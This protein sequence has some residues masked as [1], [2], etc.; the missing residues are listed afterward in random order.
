MRNALTLR[1]IA[2]SQVLF[3]LVGGVLLVFRETIEGM[4]MFDFPAPPNQWTTLLSSA[5]GNP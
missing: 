5:Q 3:F 4:N 2:A 1:T